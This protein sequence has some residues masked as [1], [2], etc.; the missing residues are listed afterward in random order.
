M[1]KRKDGLDD[2]VTLIQAMLA[3]A[4]SDGEFAE[5]ERHRIERLMNFLRFDSEARAYVDRV[6]A[7]GQA[8]EMP[9]RDELPKYET[10]LYIF[11]HALI[12]A[13]EDGVLSDDEKTHLE[14]LAEHFEL[15]QGDIEKGWTRAREMA[16]QD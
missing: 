5:V 14:A 2:R 11:Q 15:T 9:P 3:I 1:G 12:M 10:R 13:F 16:E 8:P 7:S 4:H 6:L